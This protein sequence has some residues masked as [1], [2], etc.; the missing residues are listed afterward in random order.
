M[1]FNVSLASRTTISFENHLLFIVVDS[2]RMGRSFKP[3]FQRVATTYLDPTTSSLP[4]IAHNLPRDVSD[5]RST[6][7]SLSLSSN[8]AAEIADLV[9]RTSHTSSEPESFAG[10]FPPVQ[11]GR[12]SR[13]G[14]VR[15]VIVHC[16]M[17]GGTAYVHDHI[18][19][20][21]APHAFSNPPRPCPCPFALQQQ[22]H[23]YLSPVRLRI[24]RGFI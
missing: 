8:Q 9:I 2:Y 3:C 15:L 12:P 20:F 24:N 10:V 13:F 23:L 6:F 1:Q 19:H 16:C 4:G 18:W 7:S 17:A 22:A 11:G 5:P 14:T 21:F